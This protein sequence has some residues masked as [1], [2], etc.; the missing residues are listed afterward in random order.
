MQ[1]KNKKTKAY[2]Q[3]TTRSH[4]VIDDKWKQRRKINTQLTTAR[5]PNKYKRK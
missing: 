2:V 4:K 5:E 3:T 1:H